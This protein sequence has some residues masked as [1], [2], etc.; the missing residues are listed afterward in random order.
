[1]SVLN[2]WRRRAA[3]KRPRGRAILGFE[4]L[5]ARTVLTSLWGG[6]ATPAVAAANDSNP[7]ELGVKF[8]SDV[9]GY[10]TGVS[11]YKGPGN[12]GTHVGHLWSGTGGLLAS[13]TFTGETAS[14]WQ[15][16]AFATPVAVAANTT[17]V[18]SYYAPTGHY[19]VNSGYFAGA[20]ADS[21]PLHG[22]ADGTD[23][24]NGLFVYGGD[25][26]P[27]Q[28]YNASNY[29]V[30]V[31]F[32]T[33]PVDNTP[34]TAAPEGPPAGA[35]GVKT[36]QTVLAAF[37]K[38]VQ[39]GSIALTLKDPAG[40]AVP[41]TL[42][43]DNTAH[44]VTF[45]PGAALATLTT[46]TATLSAATDLVGNPLSSPRT[47]S[48]T[49]GDP[50]HLGDWS[51]VLD[52][53][54]VVLNVALLDNGDVLM[55]D[56]GADCIGSPSA[57]LWDPLSN[58]FTSVSVDTRGDTNDI[59]CSGMTDLPDG[60][61]LVVGGHDCSGAGVGRAR[62]NIYDPATQTWSAGPD[63]T[64]ARW[65]PTATTLGD[66]QVLVTSGSDATQ[67]SYIHDPELYNPNTGSYTTLS[68][69]GLYVPAYPFMYQLPNGQVLEAGSGEY[70]T[71]IGPATPSAVLNL[72]TQ[73]WTT[74]GGPAVNG[75]TSVMYLPGKVMTTGSSY[76]ALV[77]SPDP[78][79]P[80]PSSSATYVLDATQASPQC[81]QTA[82]MAFG[83]TY[84]TLTVLPTGQVL[85]TGGSS[86]Q[87]PVNLANAV[88]P[89]ESWD[90]NTQTWTTLASEQVPRLYHSSALL[91]PDGRV[92]V[93]GG[94][95][96]F[97]KEQANESNAEIYSP[98]YLFQGPRP[99]ISS[100]PS[101]AEYAS[102]FAV[103]TPDAA[104]IASVSL[105]SLGAD[106]HAFNMNQR[107]VPLSFTQTAGGLTVQ[108]PAD[109]NTAPPG[110][111][112]LFVVNSQGVPS[113]A[114][115]IR[116]TSPTVTAT[117]PT[118]GGSGVAAGTSVTVTFSGAMDPATV[119]TSTVQLLDA[120][121]N[122]VAASVSYDAATNTATLT[123]T[124]PLASAARYT[125][126]VKGNAG[127]ARVRDTSGN[128]MGADYLST[129]QTALQSGSETY[130]LFA[131]T[132]TPGTA[133]VDDATALELG[134]KF[135]SDAA[136]YITGLRFYKGSGNTGT[137]VGHLWSSTGTLLATATFTG[138]SASGWQQVTF[139]SPVA[140]SANTVYVA[141]YYAPN[142]H[143]ADDR[144]YLTSRVDSGPLHAL[145]NYLDGSNGL[146]LSGS[147][148]FPTQSY[149]ASNYWVD[150]VFATT[151]P[152]LQVVGQAPAAG[153]TNVAVTAAVT[154][155]FNQAVQANTIG[156]TLHDA[157]NNS[158]AATLSYNAS[159]YT[160]TLTPNAALAASTTYTA[161]VSGA[162]DAAGDSLAGPVS[163]SFTTAGSLTRA[164]IWDN[165]A[166]PAV[167]SA[168]DAS[169][170]EV[171]VKFR[172]D[173]AGYI[174]GLRF[175]KGPGNTGTHAGHLWTSTGTLLATATFSGETATG[176]QEVAL[177][178]PVA[179]AANTTYVA[180]YY[181]P[182][183]GYAVSGA[184]FATAAADHA[185][186]HGLQ[187]GTDGPNGLYLYGSDT[188]PT[189]SY[190]ASNYWVDVVFSTT[191]S[192]PPTV[193]AQ[194]PAPNASGVAAGTKVT[195][196]FST[197]VQASSITFTLR[198]AAGNLANASVSYDDSSRT[199]TLTPAAPLADSTTYT[200]TVSGARDQAGN[201][202]ANPVSWS[203]STGSST[204]VSLWGGN[205]TPA[206]TAAGDV[207]AVE[208][209][210]KFRADSA[211]N[212]TGV[213]FYKGSGNTGT[214]VGH[215]WSST[216]TLLATVTFS[217]ETA[218]G[219]QQASFATPVAIKANTTYVVSY[220]APDG[221][222]AVNGA[223]FSSA[224][225]NAP[226]HG[227]ADGTDGNN[228]LY[229]YGS[230]AFPTQSYDA[231]N[232]WV[233]VLFSAAP[234][235]PTVTGQTP[236]AGA[237]GVATTVVVTAT[238][239]ESVQASTISFVLKDAGNNSVPATVSYNDS[240]HTAT[241]A[242]SAPL[243][244][245]TTYTATVSGAQEASGNAMAGPV[246]WT[247]TTA[248]GGTWVQTTAADFGAGTPSG[249]QVTNAAGGEV[250]LTPSGQGQDD[251]NGTALSSS[252]TVTSWAPFG[253]GPA[254]ATVSG[255][256]LS[257]AGCEVLS[258]QTYA[259]TGVE[260]LIS[261]G[262]TPYQ[263]FGLATD[264]SAVYGN[265][266]AMFS[267]AG[268]TNTLWARVNANGVTT[269]VNLGAL[270]GGYHVY[271]VQPVSGGFQ[272]L[273]DGVLQSMISASFPS[274]TG[275]RI[276]LSAFAGAP[277][278]PLLADWVRPLLYPANGTFVSAVFDATH[279]VTWGTATWHASTPGNTSII[280]QTRSGSTPTPDASWSDW[281]TVVVG[282]TIGSP[283][284][285]Y[286]QY[287]VLF[288][289]PDATL[290]PVLSDIS[291]AWS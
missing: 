256:I 11:F 44:T 161:T 7:V 207:N 20:A 281:A 42:A 74:L 164:T 64:Y 199:A 193:V 48:F 258:Q 33:S 176:W 67:T 49:T 225:D 139:S 173:L 248:A 168:A 68:G 134:V 196:V 270:P 107:Y 146:F 241:L 221:H 81:Q 119:G 62:T 153:A 118:F 257:V 229:L 277:A 47:W 268:T 154:A 93:A 77:G 127:G 21:A 34:L 4:V 142:G 38:A 170:V 255:G 237:T 102:S 65:Y 192:G 55:W 151:V 128:P 35:T 269:D 132:A 56:G 226:L 61:I 162:Q 91:L 230:D 28:S 169:A 144:E 140:V 141:S 191:A 204:V 271:R 82:P 166:T 99:T 115:F 96:D 80:A 84:A 238:F 66:G 214:H 36:S 41:G 165:S 224:V 198:D 15:V 172:S 121:G 109:G 263:H 71:S 76:D 135:R 19:A 123:P 73:T 60:D 233:D 45:T 8:R 116:I 113:V 222:Y 57:T 179:V 97:G 129:F 252:W 205:A 158:V 272:F 159:T 10:V 37:N 254:S 285:R 105:V 32:N 264:F 87:D 54:L 100:A 58:T 111:Y 259:G 14:G 133:S 122:A 130:S 249:T 50:A 215:L 265:Y 86:T 200:A 262:A 220:F 101:T 85:A 183:G 70:D 201:A 284:N 171:G 148:S 150:V 227:L 5:E 39:A 94:G 16:A 53:P 212:V 218:S 46:Y 83:R 243:A 211:G 195:A 137:H 125:I 2:C 186:L 3:K 177:A 280:V 203:F 103:Q 31:Y 178:S 247:F 72:Q 90:P 167:S 138:E 124:A 246:S 239:N 267:T 155:T 40:N 175:Y 120:S 75:G 279:T 163:W 209:G 149:A 110:Y 253:G 51:D 240:T 152:G 9:A 98:S 92:L 206:V 210:M 126:V 79:N 147:D 282:A 78:T 190:N 89:A 157:A 197:S 43:Y 23:G 228:G 117:T 136:G 250:Q 174:T 273:V 236:A 13:T 286:L 59:F 184:Y 289:T 287:E 223:G 291:L 274:G 182:A 88:Y 63:M 27:T 160:A 104:N 69:A 187:N 180:S 188:F 213:S 26:F 29:W 24:P 231:A 260:G 275:L 232:Y 261:F 112:M 106:T 217:G 52:W 288:A 244:G 266:W 131:P 216:G 1:M 17:Y 278:A 18:V 95:R 143:Y 6:T 242:P 189:Q 234:S 245:T 185:P 25:Q 208:L 194:T 251:F 181:A 283:T 156:F 108:A 276:A 145:A 219:W 30:D 235:G 22:L 114:S 12:T 202:M 290:T